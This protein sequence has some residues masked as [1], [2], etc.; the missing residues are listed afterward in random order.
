MTSRLLLLVTMALVPASLGLAKPPKEAPPPPAQT[1]PP[2]AET[3][4]AEPPGGLTL[5]PKDRATALAKEGAEFARNAHYAEAASKFQQSVLV[6]P[7]T[8]VFYNLA[9]T[10]EQLG[11]WKGCVD[12]YTAYLA[13][14]RGEHDRADPPE[15]AAVNRSIEKCRETAQ[16]PISITSSPEGAQ[17]ALAS[18]DRVVGTTPFEMKLDP[19]SYTIFVLKD[20]FT[21]VETKVV[22][23]PK[24]PGKF[25]FDLR[26]VVNSGKVRIK[27]NI[28]DAMIFIDGKNYGITPF[29]D[30]PELEVGRHQVVVKRD[31]YTSVNRTFEITKG[32]TTEL[33]V[34]MFLT[35]PPPSWRSY[36][37]WTSI[38]LGALAIGGGAVA[39]VFAEDEF[40]DTDDFEQLE[41]F[42]NLGYYL[43]GSLFA[44]GLGL[45]I[46]EAAIDRVNDDDLIQAGIVP[47]PS[48]MPIVGIAPTDDGFFMSGGVRF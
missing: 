25:H 14:F 18:R 7:M 24:Q 13:G 45:V 10:H 21:P 12:N 46:W 5:T 27:A 35:N 36:L 31:D 26:P 15:I 19:G 4:P 2:K 23:Q 41:L 3:P 34:D 1:E 40:N 8:D 37:G 6:F 43:G 39:F 38:S 28:R 29:E 32:Q 33:D 11:D 30:T 9:Y 42:Q 47:A 22:V 44:V 20:G 16:P 17:V 48:I